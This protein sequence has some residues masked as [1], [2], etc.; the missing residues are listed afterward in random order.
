[1]AVPAPYKRSR[2]VRSAL[3]VHTYLLRYSGYRLGRRS[4]RGCNSTKTHLPPS[5]LAFVTV[6]LV[7][8]WYSP[9]CRPPGEPLT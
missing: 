7:C 3:N 8:P 4:F 9:T 1:M 6:G 2:H 5:F